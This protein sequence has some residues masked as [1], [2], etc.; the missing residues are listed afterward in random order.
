MD[1]TTAR[2]P[3]TRLSRKD[4]ERNEAEA[5]ISGD[6]GRREEARNALYSWLEREGDEAG[7]AELKARWARED[8]P[9]PKPP[10]LP[11]PPVPPKPSRKTLRELEATANTATASAPP[12]VTEVAHPNAEPGGIGPS[13]P[14]IPAAVP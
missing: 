10:R 3:A 1:P 13:A 11:A 9:P 4:L 12:I 2:R 7:L 8:A 5:D 14:P 6:P